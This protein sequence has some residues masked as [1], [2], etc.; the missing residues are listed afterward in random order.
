LNAFVIST[1][2]FSVTRVLCINRV[3]MHQ[4][5]DNDQRSKGCT[6]INNDFPQAFRAPRQE[7]K[8]KSGH[9]SYSTQKTLA[10]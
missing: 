3:F 6:Y 2:L 9:Y 10:M 4:F 7:A 8:D 1:V 5:A